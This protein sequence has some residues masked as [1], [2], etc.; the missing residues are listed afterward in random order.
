MGVPLLSCTWLFTIGSND[1]GF[2]HWPA[3]VAVH[4]PRTLPMS[5]ATPSHSSSWGLIPSFPWG[6]QDHSSYSSV[7]THCFFLLRVVHSSSFN[8]PQ[9]QCFHRWHHQASSLLSLWQPIWM[10]TGASTYPKPAILQVFLCHLPLG[11]QTAPPIFLWVSPS[12][13][14]FHPPL[15]YLLLV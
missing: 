15:F 12:P 1:F 8:N 6:P 7:W 9:Y 3:P 13:S 2:S 11:A 5:L 10:S 14:P 4:T